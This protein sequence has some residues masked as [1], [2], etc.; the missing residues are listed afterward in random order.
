MEIFPTPPSNST[1]AGV[2]LL[3][4]LWRHLPK[5]SFRFPRLKVHV[6]QDTPH[7]FQTQI[8]SPGASD[9]PAPDPRFPQLPLWVW[10]SGRAAQRSPWNI[11]LLDHPFTIKGYNSGKARWKRCLRQ[12]GREGL[13]AS[14]PPLPPSVQ[15]STCSPTQK[16]SKPHP[17]EILWRL[18]YAGVT[19]SI[20]GQWQLNSISSNLS[21]PQ[22]LDWKVQPCHRTVGFPGNQPPSLRDLEVFQKLPRLT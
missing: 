17:F 15:I 21:P 4:Q 12:G 19:A 3:N 1:P 6:P 10:L 20:T 7:P 22:R 2:L 14:T 11:L 5:D 18:H 16:P 8:A 13:R 9:R